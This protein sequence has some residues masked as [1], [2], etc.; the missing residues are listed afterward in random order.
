MNSHPLRLTTLILFTSLQLTACGGGGGGGNT[1]SNEASV[2]DNVIKD[3]DR[4][5]ISDTADNCPNVPNTNQLDTDRDLLGDEC[6]DD[7][8]NDTLTNGQELTLGTNPSV[9]DSDADGINDNVDV[10]PLDPKYT[11]ESDSDKIPDDLDNC[12]VVANPEQDDTDHDSL[13]D[14]CDDDIDNDTLKNDVEVRHGTDPTRADTD[15]D[16][17]SDKVDPHPLD[18]LNREDTDDDYIADVIDNCKRTSNVDQK[19]LDNDGS[20][21]ACD[22]ILPVSQFDFGSRSYL[23]VTH[24]SDD[25]V[26]SPVLFQK[27][28]QDNFT[29]VTNFHNRYSGNKFSAT[30]V[31]NGVVTSTQL[32][33]SLDEGCFSNSEPV[34]A[35]ND[36][37]LQ[38]KCGFIK[39]SGTTGEVKFTENM[40]WK[41][42]FVKRNP[43][44]GHIYTEENAGLSIYDA[45]IN[46]LSRV[47]IP[48]YYPVNDI[49]FESNRVVSNGYYWDIKT[50]DK[51]QQFEGLFDD[52]VPKLAFIPLPARARFTN[53]SVEVDHAGI[54][55]TQTVQMC[56]QRYSIEEKSYGPL[57]SISTLTA[58]ESYGDAYPHFFYDSKGNL[59]LVE[60]L[61]NGEQSKLRISSNEGGQWHLL[62]SLN[63]IN[64]RDLPR[65][66]YDTLHVA[67]N[68]D[69]YFYTKGSEKIRFF[70]FKKQMDGYAGELVLVDANELQM[71]GQ[72]IFTD[73]RGGVYLVIYGVGKDEAYFSALQLYNLRVGSTQ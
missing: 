52:S 63:G 1:N 3:A 20:G 9:A 57:E 68:G 28:D 58:A 53:D 6:D 13:G 17:S 61:H 59:H 4:D 36:A 10:F 29:L 62:A 49:D 41:S 35:N 32:R 26:T 5:I 30:V 47:R 2:N 18:F 21:D 64:E 16:G 48:N 27:R 25:Y 50:P 43:K 44:T 31:K 14:V 65:Y 45:D 7:I 54:C 38:T 19:D 22:P 33:E 37:Y 23:A 67:P 60:L 24:S 15:G 71:A 56:R 42:G 69:L 72:D 12:P 11:H 34:Y 46:L 51:L 55:Y 8:D 40:Y 66:P 73:P 70:F 39:Y